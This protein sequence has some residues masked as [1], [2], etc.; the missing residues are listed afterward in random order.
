LGGSWAE[1]Q[2]FKIESYPADW[3]KYKRAAG[4]IR[5][6]QM[7]DAKPDLVIAFP[8]RNGTRNMVDQAFEAD[9]PIV[10]V[11]VRK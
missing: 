1:E 4:Y 7:L 3:K 5:N 6:K 8:G 2:G 11:S 10:K 9:I